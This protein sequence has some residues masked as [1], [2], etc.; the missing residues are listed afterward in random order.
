MPVVGASVSVYYVNGTCFVTKTDAFGTV[1]IAD[2]N[3]GVYVLVVE[4]CGKKVT[5]KVPVVKGVTS[6][7][8]IEW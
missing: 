4:M 2:L 8:E 5:Q 3:P 6:N 1:Y 7:V